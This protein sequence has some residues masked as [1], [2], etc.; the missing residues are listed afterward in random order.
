MVRIVLCV[1]VPII[2][3]S[4]IIII[5][6]AVVAPSSSGFLWLLIA[7]TIVVYLVIQTDVCIVCV[8]E[9]AHEC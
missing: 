1:S 2:S 3:F 9:R 5:I 7:G 4:I 8:R 6:V